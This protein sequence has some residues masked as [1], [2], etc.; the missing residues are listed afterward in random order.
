MNR[1]LIEL[2]WELAEKIVE[3]QKNS[4][5]GEGLLAQMSKD[6]QAEFPDM[7]GFSL[8]NLKYMR[9]WYCF[10]VGDDTNGQQLVAQNEKSQ[11]PVGQF[12]NA[13]QLVSQIP[14]GHNLLF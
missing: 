9:Q 10:W 14:W 12:V 11:Q 6:L 4:Q 1:E 8:S 3:K 7:R 13:K 5:C 2:Y